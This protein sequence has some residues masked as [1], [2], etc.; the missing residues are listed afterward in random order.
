MQTFLRTIGS[1]WLASLLLMLLLVSMAC[2]TILE[3]MHGAERALAAIYHI[4][5]FKCLLLLLGANLL[6]SMLVRYPF[7][8]RQVGFILTHTGILVTLLGALTT[9]SFGIDGQVALSEGHSVTELAVPSETLVIRNLQDQTR[10]QVSLGPSVAG[11]LTALEGADMPVHEVRGVRVCIKRYLPDTRPQSRVVN[12]NPSTRQAVEVSLSSSGFERPQWL[13]ADEPTQVGNRRTLFR[14]VDDPDQLQRLLHDP[15]PATPAS[16]GKIMLKHH[17]T[18]QELDLEDCLEHAVSVGDTG[19]T[20]RVLRYL[21]HATVGEDNRLTNLS[22]KPLNP[23]IEAELA[24]PSATERL[25][26][27]ARFPDFQSMH[28]KKDFDWL[29]VTFEAPETAVERLPVE[30][31]LDGDGVLHARFDH[32]NSVSQQRLV[33]G[34]S[35]DTP[36]PGLK[37]TVLNKYDRA[38]IDRVVEEVSPVRQK[39]Q[40]AILANLKTDKHNAE[41]W[42]VK[43]VP[44]SVNIDGVP[45]E[46]TYGDKTLPLGFELKLNRFRIGY[47]PGGSRPRSFESHVTIIDPASGSPQDRVI[48]MNHPTK[49]GGYTIYQSSYRK[50]PN[51]TA[52][53]LSVSKDPGRPIVF[54]GYI[55]TLVGML[56]VIIL[57]MSDKERSPELHLQRYGGRNRTNHRKPARTRRPVPLAVGGTCRSA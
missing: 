41:M 45:Y 34:Q 8:R 42:L 7:N 14:V 44:R 32:D 49:Y 55:T 30:I 43:H 38:R 1:M 10:R 27:F 16:L 31:L 46:L 52:S 53:I 23:A 17:G 22:A 9:Q 29:K 5:W 39:R 33:V 48:S 54:A 28:L 24:G 51:E 2:A 11:G 21:P 4:W 13:F 6:A 3:S 57:R 12:E 37:L 50:G 15:P 25:I 20:F 19:F 56:L 47:Y 40:P 35:V 26:A 18:T 36:W